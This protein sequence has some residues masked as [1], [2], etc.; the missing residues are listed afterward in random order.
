MTVTGPKLL[1]RSTFA[2]AHNPDEAD[3]SEKIELN[4]DIGYV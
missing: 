2:G 1:R 4:D 3:Q